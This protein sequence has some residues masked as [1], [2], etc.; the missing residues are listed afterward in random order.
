MSPRTALI[1]G[2]SGQDGSNLTEHLALVGE[3]LE[4]F[5]QDDQL[6]TSARLP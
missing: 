2:I 1:T 4:R 5:Q 3:E 6:T